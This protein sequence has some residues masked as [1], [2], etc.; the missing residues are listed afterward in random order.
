MFQNGCFY[1]W[2]PS[3]ILLYVECYSIEFVWDG[4]GLDED[5]TNEKQR[6][7]VNQ[8][9]PRIS[10]ELELLWYNNMAPSDGN[11]ERN[12]ERQLRYTDRVIHM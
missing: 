10:S 1:F 11:K 6:G 5:V 12:K 4:L 2:N 7:W 3:L 8:T 9:L